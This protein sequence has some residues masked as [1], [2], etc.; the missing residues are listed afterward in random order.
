MNTNA[1]RF[2]LGRKIFLMLVTVLLLYILVVLV[3][4]TITDFQPDE[5]LQLEP[6]KSADQ[7]IISD[8]IISLTTWN[9]G[10]AGLGRD[11]SFFYSGGNMWLAGTKMV[12]PSR[13]MT[14]RY[15][16]GI[17][18]T[19]GAIQADFFLLQEVDFHSKRSYYIN[20]FERIGEQLPEF[21]AFF[22]ANYRS[23]R[24][25]LPI[26]EPWRAYGKVNSGLAS[27][28]RY[29]PSESGRWQ[30]PGEYSWPVRIFHLDR[31]V[32][33]HRFQTAFGRQLVIA[34]VHNSAFDKGGKLKEAQMGFLRTFFLKEYESG[35]FVIAGGDWNQCPPF[36]QTQTLNPQ[37]DL[38]YTP[39][40]IDA[41]FMPSDWHWIYDA[42]TPTIR[43]TTDAYVKGRTMVSVIDFFLV[44]PN[45]KVLNVR[46]IETE[47]RF[48]D[49][50]PVWM[51]VELAP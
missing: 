47:F 27:Y 3:H 9:L 37:Q 17:L 5:N 48:S 7:Q 4:G 8:S 49:H 18:Q 13:E 39:I 21:S 22:A 40:N 32:S 1:D 33:V 46:A 43:S 2:R 15:F 11:A 50:Q 14:N 6:Y 45:V 31:C 29:H 34:N 19:I 23:P 36:F 24:V 10:Y 38:K 28:A 42:R 26:F 16:E 51:E 44:S 12:R 35:N 20:Q 25:P 41:E 30:L